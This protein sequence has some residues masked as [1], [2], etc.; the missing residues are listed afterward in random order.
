MEILVKNSSA[1]SEDVNALRIYPNPTSDKINIQ[2]V[3]MTH[4]AIYSTLGQLMY[5]ANVHSDEASVEVGQFPAGAYIVRVTCGDK[6]SFTQLI[7]I[8]K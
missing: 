8:V 4:I 3:D 5:E 2:G 6:A 7:N 1:V